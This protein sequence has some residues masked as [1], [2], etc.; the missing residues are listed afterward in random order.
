[1]EAQSRQVKLVRDVVDPEEASFEAFYDAVGDFEQRFERRTLDD[2]RRDLLSDLRT[3][4][5]RI[6]AEL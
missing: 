4:R 3:I 2:V 6:R 1:M 5:E